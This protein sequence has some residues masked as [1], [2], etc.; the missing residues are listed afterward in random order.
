MGTLIGYISSRDTKRIAEELTVLLPGQ[1]QLVRYLDTSIRRARG[2]LFT[3]RWIGMFLKPDGQHRVVSEQDV[4][5][6]G[7]HLDTSAVILL[8]VHLRAHD[9][10]VLQAIMKLHL[11]LRGDLINVLEDSRPA[12][13]N[14]RYL[15][16]DDPPS[17]ACLSGLEDEPEAPPGSN[18]DAEDL[19]TFLRIFMCA[20]AML[21]GI[22]ID[23]R[24][25]T[26]DDESVSTSG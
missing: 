2:T 8:A 20:L 24:H 6:L 7:V 12:P 21:L 9:P 11:Y 14:L 23:P 5:R 18:V 16:A 15:S 10:Q 13:N 1:P 19:I 17:V 22:E 4:A 25:T 3:A 26:T